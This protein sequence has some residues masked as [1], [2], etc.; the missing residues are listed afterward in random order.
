MKIVSGS[1]LISPGKNAIVQINSI[2][3]TILVRDY[4]TVG[5]FLIV[6]VEN[7]GQTK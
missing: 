1:S 5:T 2:C 7:N 3:G 6:I 4:M